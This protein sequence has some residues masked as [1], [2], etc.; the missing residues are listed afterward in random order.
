MDANAVG[1]LEPHVGGSKALLHVPET[2][3]IFVRV[4]G[5][6][7]RQKVQNGISGC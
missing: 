6:T 2:V 5:R 3:R 7:T 4:I 1:S